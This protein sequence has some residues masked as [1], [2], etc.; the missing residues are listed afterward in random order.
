VGDTDRQR[1]DNVLGVRRWIVPRSGVNVAVPATFDD[2]PL[3]APA[4]WF[5]DEDASQTFLAEMGVT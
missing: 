5:G 3:N 1:L 4:W 2:V